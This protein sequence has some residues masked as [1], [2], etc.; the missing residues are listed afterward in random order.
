VVGRKGSYYAAGV[1]GGITGLPFHWGII[2][3]IHKDDKEANSPTVREDVWNWYTT[4]F[5]T[6]KTEAQ[7][8]VLITLTR[9]HQ[10]DLPG[11][12]LELARRDPKADQW[13]VVR[14]PAILEDE[15]QR[16]PGDP[17]R[18]GDALWEERH[19]VRELEVERLQAG[20]V[21]WSAVYQQDPSPARGTVFER[22]HFRYFATEPHP[23]G[24]QLLLLPP[25]GEGGE[26][27]VPPPQPRR[28]L[29]ADCRWFQTCD[30]AD[31]VGSASA[32]TCVVTFCVTPQRDLL[33]WH[34]WRG[35]LPYPARYNA[36]IG[37]RSGVGAWDDGSHQWQPPFVPWPKRL[38]YQAMEFKASGIAL[39][40][41][42][43]AEGKPF[44]VLRPGNMS[45]V[46]R[47][48]NVT[49]LYHNGK[50]YHR[51]GQPWL[52]SFEA[53]VLN[54][55][56]GTF[57]DQVDCLA[58]GGILLAQDSI[59]TAGIEGDLICWPP[60]RGVETEGNG[61]T[62]EHSTAFD[63]HGQPIEFEDER[64]WYLQGGV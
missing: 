29:A 49:T 58:Y 3:D 1:R 9:W 40:Q 33:V 6:R 64:P 48:S 12:L 30:A 36:I 37:L 26:P 55:P 32:F 20:P 2:D 39:V 63:Y 18:V 7:A 23:R 14:F 5:A 41:Q 22:D 15:G 25:A 11:R 43:A 53:E 57:A 54:F 42:G 31:T 8:R 45:K 19:P 38:V 28:V 52:T 50:V 10:D 61:A 13:T 56:S 44:R 59:L 35:K 34:V 27:G 46:E 4:T 62:E 51:Q 21:K 60:P 17:R 16:M 47:C 24:V